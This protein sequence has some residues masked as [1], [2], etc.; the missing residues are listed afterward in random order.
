[1]FSLADAHDHVCKEGSIVNIG[2]L[3]CVN[4]ETLSKT[5]KMN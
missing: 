2:G 4:D 5:S 1:M 3:L